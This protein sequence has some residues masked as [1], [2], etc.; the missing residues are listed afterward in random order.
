LRGLPRVVGE[1]SSIAS[2]KVEGA[3]V[4]VAGEDTRTRLALVE[5]EPFLGLETIVSR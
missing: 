4:G 1:H 3:S 2:G 5:V